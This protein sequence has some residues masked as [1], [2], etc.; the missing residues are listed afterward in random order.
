MSDWTIL[1]LGIIYLLLV[2]IE[3]FV[4]FS[5][6]KKKAVHLHEERVMNPTSGADGIQ[7]DQEVFALEK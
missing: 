5:R 6:S 4:K 1:A 7:E 3:V 2:L